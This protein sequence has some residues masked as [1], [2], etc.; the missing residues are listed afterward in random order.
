M[1][2][3]AT[4]FSPEIA[5]YSEMFKWSFR[6]SSFLKRRIFLSLQFFSQKY[7]RTYC[8]IKDSPRSRISESS[9]EINSWIHENITRVPRLQGSQRH[10]NFAQTGC[11][12]LF[13]ERQ[14]S[15]CDHFSQNQELDQPLLHYYC[16]S[17][18]DATIE[19]VGTGS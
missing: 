14:M 13:A 8:H 3:A 5:L 2:Q 18:Q 11:G 1:N 16:Y 19:K 12:I 15:T 7:C 4:F 17:K 9:R 6:C 10:V